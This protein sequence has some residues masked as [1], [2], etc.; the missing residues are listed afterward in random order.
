[1]ADTVRHL[2]EEMIPE[3]ED[4]QQRGYFNKAEIKAIVKKRQDFEYLLKRRAALKQDFLR[5]V[6]SEHLLRPAE[7]AFSLARCHVEAAAAAAFPDAAT[8][9]SIALALFD[10]TKVIDIYKITYSIPFYPFS[11]CFAC[12]FGSAAS[13]PFICTPRSLNRHSLLHLSPL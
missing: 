11:S 8:S 1:M 3:L 4:F 12:A 7:A 10:F 2:M 6:T 9:L 5:L 13:V